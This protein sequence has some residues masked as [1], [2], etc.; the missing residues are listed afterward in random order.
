MP[1]QFQRAQNLPGLARSGS[2][3]QMKTQT[4]E[5]HRDGRATGARVP[6]QNACNRTQQRHWIDTGV[7]G[8]MFVFELKCGVDKFR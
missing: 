5:L 6:R 7:L 2:G 1:L 8:E 3:L 4:G